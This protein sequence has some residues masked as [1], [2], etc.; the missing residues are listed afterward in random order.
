MKKENEVKEVKEV[1]LL[2]T[3]LETTSDSNVKQY[4][5]LKVFISVFELIEKFKGNT[6]T[7]N[8][9]ITFAKKKNSILDW[10]ELQKDADLVELAK[11]GKITTKVI[12]HKI[13]YNI[14]K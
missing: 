14:K 11:Q 8:Q 3:L 12:K 9:I 5:G 1:V 7:C 4:E 6:D 10:I 13:Y 2:D